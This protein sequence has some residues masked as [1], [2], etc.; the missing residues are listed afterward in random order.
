MP[1]AAASARQETWTV[2]ALCAT[3]ALAVLALY[4][5]TR[6]FEFISLDDQY[7]LV[8]RPL[9]SNGLS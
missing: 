8:Q 4:W 6:D 7:V 2:A 5:Q 1:R 9:V 3:L